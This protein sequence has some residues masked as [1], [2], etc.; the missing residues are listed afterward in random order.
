MANPHR[1]RGGFTSRR[2]TESFS[3][4][5]A[6]GAQEFQTPSDDVPN[7]RGRGGSRGPSLR[8]AGRGSSLNALGGRGGLTGGRGIVPPPRGG[9]GSR[10]RGRGQPGVLW[11]TS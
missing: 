9:G 6:N 10:G 8:G 4:H 7:Y 11:T 1:G 2:D 3:N 5:R